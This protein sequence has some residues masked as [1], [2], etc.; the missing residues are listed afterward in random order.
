VTDNVSPVVD[1]PGPSSPVVDRIVALAGHVHADA[2]LN[3]AHLKP[4]RLVRP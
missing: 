4:M 2:H 3:D 1:L